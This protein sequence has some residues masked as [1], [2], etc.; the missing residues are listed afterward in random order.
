MPFHI[1]SRHG[2][3]VITAVLTIAIL[4][5]PAP[6]LSLSFS[7][8]TT[9]RSAA[10]IFDDTR[11]LLSDDVRTN[12]IKQMRRSISISK[13]KSNFSRNTIQMMSITSSEEETDVVSNES[14]SSSSS[15]SPS[16]SVI[17]KS[18]FILPHNANDV[19]SKF[20]SNSPYGNPSIL[21]AVEQLQKKVKWFS[22]DMVVADIVLMPE[23]EEEFPNII[24]QRAL[25]ADALVVFNLE[26]DIDVTYVNDLFKMRKNKSSTDEKEVG[27]VNFYRYVAHTI[28][29]H[30]RL[31][32]F[33]PGV[34]LQVPNGWMNK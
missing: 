15:S 1:K 19:K 7:S 12:R 20:G 29:N 8:S 4:I 34:V 21:E 3:V 30:H 23:N 10:N 28:Q 16:K 5:I 31:V 33:L 27:L 24:K 25:D 32:L 17:G 13:S 26:R 14:S 2:I 18:L 9:S 6:A 11:I 22:D